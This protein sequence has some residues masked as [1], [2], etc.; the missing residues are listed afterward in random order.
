ME[1]G[2]GI[3]PGDAPPQGILGAEADLLHLVEIHTFDDGLCWRLDRLIGLLRQFLGAGAQTIEGKRSCRP[4]FE[5][6]RRT[7][8][9]PSRGWSKPHGREAGD[10]FTSRKWGHAS[11]SKA[12]CH[13]GQRWKSWGKNPSHVGPRILPTRSMISR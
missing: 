10:K 2:D 12:N 9:S 8:L 4:Q 13:R 6:G 7:G 1:K 3:G 11:G 5:A